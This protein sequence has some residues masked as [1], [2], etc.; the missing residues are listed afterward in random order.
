MSNSGH[1]V[2]HTSIIVRHNCILFTLEECGTVGDT[3]NVHPS[4]PIATNCHVP[5]FA[6]KQFTALY[7]GWDR[8][9]IA[10]RVDVRSAQVKGNKS[11][12]NKTAAPAR[13]VKLSTAAARYDISI[14]T[15]RLWIA[16]GTIT[17]HRAGERIIRVDLDELDRMFGI[18]R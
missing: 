17:A 8:S 2:P 6:R 14:K 7:A 11:Q 10:G 13:F 16:R 9:K 1:N 3:P 12:M 5:L 4:I 18:E 15:L